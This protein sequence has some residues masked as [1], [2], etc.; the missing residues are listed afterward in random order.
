MRRRNFIAGLGSTMAAW[1][2]AAL[3]QQPTRKIPK[4]GV[5]W[6]AGSAEEEGEYFTS[7]QQGFRDL[8]YIEGQTLV[9]EHRFAAEQYDRFKSF[10]A[11]LVALNVDVLVAV[12]RPATAAAQAATTTIPIVFITVPD[13]VGNKFADNLARPGKNLTG[14]SGGAKLLAI[15]QPQ[16]DN[17]LI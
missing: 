8:G 14:L 1:P 17:R 9:F 15:V 2:L 13:P 3:A 12:T 16:V 10:A 4:I 6:H 11:E 5:L 7:F